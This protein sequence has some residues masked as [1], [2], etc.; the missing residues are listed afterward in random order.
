[1]QP[2]PADRR[3]YQAEF[4]AELYGMPVGSQLRYA[5]GV[6]AR[7]GAL[8]STLGSLGRLPLVL[9]PPAPA[10]RRFRC[11]SL[12]WH[13]WRTFATTDGQRYLACGVCAKEKPPPPHWAA[14][15]SG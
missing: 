13:Y 15:A 3:R 1:M 4:V 2:T 12:H 5:T 14:G 11:R 7:A 6:L 9:G 8:R 10:W